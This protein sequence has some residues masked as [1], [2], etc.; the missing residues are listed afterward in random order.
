MKEILILSG[1]GGTG[2]T[3]FS[4]SFI[5]FTKQCIVCD[6]DVDASNLP[7]LLKPEKLKSYEFSAG[8]RALIN[9]ELC[10]ACG[11]CAALCRFEAIDAQFQVM[12]L[13][14]EG[15]GFC[16]HVCPT[17]AITMY[18]RPS[19]RWFSGQSQQ[20]QPM[21][22]AELKPGEENSG[23]LVAQVKMKARQKGEADQIPL[24][25]ADGPPGIGCAVISSMVGVD[26]V[27]LLA[28]PSHSS[29]HDLERLSQL[30]K[31]RGIK[32]GVII[33]KWDYNPEVCREIEAWAH[34][35]DL[36]VWGRI[37]FSP[38][39]ADCITNAEIPGSNPEIQKLLLPL[40]EK[41][42]QQLFLI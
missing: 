17:Q 11:L 28:E 36:P 19:G 9:R 12:D 38:Q 37:P 3:S 27:V 26:L 4:S 33:N 24:I 30:M 35:T 42:V 22:F 39:I 10:T 34:H 1:K 41:I 5:F 7:L 20:G 15:C 14:C 31:S 2:K 6:Y 18:A 32:G 21:F 13:S 40:W 29:L 25:I 8:K 16:A 23:K